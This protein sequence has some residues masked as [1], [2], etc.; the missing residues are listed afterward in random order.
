MEKKKDNDLV[1]E[2]TVEIRMVD[3]RDAQLDS[4]ASYSF[5]LTVIEGSDFGAVFHIDRAEMILG[6]SDEVDFRIND[7]RAS[8]RHLMFTFLPV[9]GGEK[10]SV[11]A[12]DLDS[13]NGTYVNN[14]KIEDLE[15]KNGDKLKV[16]DTILKFEVKDTLDISY[17]EKLYNQATRDPL[18]GLWN[19]NYVQAE[20]DKIISLSSRY[21][22]PFSLLLFDIDFFK[23]V[24]D[25]YGHHVGDLVLKKTA[26][27]IMSQLRAH[28]VAGR[29]GGEEFIS[30]MPDTSIE[31][32]LVAAERLR[33]EIELFDFSLFGCLRRVTISIGIAQFPICGRTSEEL[34]KQ[35][36][37]ALYTAK[38]TGRNRVSVAALIE[39]P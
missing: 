14:E 37:A 31:G 20:F 38:Q 29:Y 25:T 27:L 5:T 24:N 21:N 8:R 16:G 15:L 36:D 18:T 13:K 35:A 33:Q 7:S 39:T 9:E 4:S 12:I 28:D 6:R 26:Q 22:R 34:I 32:A 10:V 1:N 3:H 30:L 19:R 2:Q 23:S 17:H 11:M